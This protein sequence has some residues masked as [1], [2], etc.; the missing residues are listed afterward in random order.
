[1]SNDGLKELYISQQDV[2]GRIRHVLGRV[3]GVS[4]GTTPWATWVD[5]ALPET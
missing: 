3:F 1:M 4:A 2:N 5:L